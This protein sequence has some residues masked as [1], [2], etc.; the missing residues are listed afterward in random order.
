[1]F[2]RAFEMAQLAFPLTLEP[3]CEWFTS[4]EIPG[5]YPEYPQGWGGVNA[6]GYQNPDFDQACQA[7]R[8]TLPEAAQYRQANFQA[9]AIFARDLPV[10]PLYL[11]LNVLAARPGLCGLRLDASTVSALWNVET[12][13]EGVNCRR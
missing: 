10:I 8:T 9:Q 7:G 6:A 3:S 5:P 1:M 11:R 13:N 2:G 12:W 4:A